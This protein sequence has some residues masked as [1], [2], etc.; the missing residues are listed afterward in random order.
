[1]LGMSGSESPVGARWFYPKYFLFK[2]SLCTP[3][4]W[5]LEFWGCLPWDLG[6]FTSAF[7]CLL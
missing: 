6:I 1:M 5:W 7:E 2:G 3:G 4:V